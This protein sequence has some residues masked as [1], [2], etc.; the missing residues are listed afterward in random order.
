MLSIT[1]QDTL[2]KLIHDLKNPISVIYSSLHLIEYQ[3]PEVKNYQY[4][5]DT[6]NDLEKLKL[7]LQNYTFI[8]SNT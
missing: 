2:V 8:K 7:F 5:N 3:H 1:D 4:W 6:M